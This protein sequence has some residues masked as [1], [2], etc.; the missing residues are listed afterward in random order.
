MQIADKYPDVRL[1]TLGQNFAEEP[2]LELDLQKV[3]LNWTSTSSGI[4]QRGVVN[5][6]TFD[7]NSLSSNLTN[8]LKNKNKSTFLEALFGPDWKY[9]SAV[10]WIYGRRLFDLYKIPIGLIATDWGGT[11]VEAW[12]SPEAL[13]KC[14]LSPQ[15]SKS[16]YP[17]DRQNP[18]LYSPLQPEPQVEFASTSTKT[19]KRQRNVMENKS[20]KNQANKFQLRDSY[21]IAQHEYTEGQ[22]KTG[23]S[24][25]KD[26]ISDNKSKTG[27]MLHPLGREVIDAKLTESER[28]YNNR[29][30]KHGGGFQGRFQRPGKPKTETTSEWQKPFTDQ[31]SYTVLWNAM[32]HPFIKT[33]IKGAIWYQGIFSWLFQKYL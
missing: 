20:R 30:H 31:N 26:S 24:I 17:R 22:G 3:F 23:S 9:F 5:F 15:P 18:H 6:L 7:K 25:K 14:G 12:S 29:K 13:K 1:F 8:K 10:C 19:S 28:H 4:C 33:T 16:S 2:L 21:D 11:C 27:S 32:I